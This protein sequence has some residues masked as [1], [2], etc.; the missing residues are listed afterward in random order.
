MLSDRLREKV[1]ISFPQDPGREER[2]EAFDDWLRLRFQVPL[3]RDAL[4]GPAFGKS[5][6][7]LGV[8]TIGAGLAS[9]AITTASGGDWATVV[10]ASLGII[11]GVLATI[12]QIWRPSERSVARYQAAFA[13]RREGWAYLQDRGRYE[14]VAPE[15][16]LPA[17]IDEVTRIH[18]AVELVDEATSASQTGG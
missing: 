14:R 7:A 1:R 17:F 16:R 15:D 13:L 8:A 3:E 5:A 18:R 10:V 2:P 6:T 4:A 9:S 12:N 11:V